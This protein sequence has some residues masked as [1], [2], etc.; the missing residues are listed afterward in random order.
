MKRKI[1][2]LIIAAIAITGFMEPVSKKVVLDLGTLNFLLPEY[3]NGNVKVVKEIPYEVNLENG[4]P[5]KGI[6]ATSKVL[7]DQNFASNFSAYFYDFGLVSKFE[8]LNDGKVASYWVSETSNGRYS[9]TKYFRNDTLF[10]Y[11]QFR[12]DDKGCLE[13]TSSFY[14]KNDS[15]LGRYAFKTDNNCN[16]IEYRFFNQKGISLNRHEIIR[17]KS[18]RVIERNVYNAN[19]SLVL[20][21]ISAYNEKGFCILED[22]KSKKYGD[23][24]YTYK[25]L[26][27]DKY[28]NWLTLIAYKNDK[29]VFFVER[30]YEYY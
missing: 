2:F 11:G 1:A 27:Y 30:T 12:Y 5:T 25:Y 7:A 15:I 16:Y 6:R 26:T 28:E 18:G 3:L 9:G 10:S 24:K 13:E 23:V 29:P 4:E 17:D 19:D 8:Y 21:K 14:S 20:K 22:V